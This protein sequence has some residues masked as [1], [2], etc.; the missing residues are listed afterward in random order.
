MVGYKLSQ[1]IRSDVRYI[2]VHKRRASICCAQKSL[3][4]TIYVSHWIRFFPLF[5]F[6][7]LLAL[8]CLNEYEHIKD[9]TFCASL[10]C[11]CVLDCICSL[12]FRMIHSRCTLF[13]YA[14]YT[15]LSLQ[16]L[17]TSTSLSLSIFAPNLNQS[18]HKKYYSYCALHIRV[19][20]APHHTY[21]VY[22]CECVLYGL[23][24]ELSVDWRGDGKRF[25]RFAM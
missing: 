4:A 16:I 17:F 21:Y 18:Q 1:P 23:L 8:V 10:R 24:N 12:L 19:H 11:V 22:V 20:E 15:H 7:L 9:F 2:A 3:C 6:F 25:E 14:T 13:L 5:Y